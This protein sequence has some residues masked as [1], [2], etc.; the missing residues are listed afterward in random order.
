[1]QCNIGYKRTVDVACDV[2]CSAFIA[3]HLK[4]NGLNVCIRSFV[5]YSFEFCLVTFKNILFGNVSF[6][7][8]DFLPF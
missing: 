7:K 4:P 2:S 1:M 6:N 5:M 3:T 8:L